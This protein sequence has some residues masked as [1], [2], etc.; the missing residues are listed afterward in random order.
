[1][2]LDGLAEHRDQASVRGT[3]RTGRVSKA[4]QKFLENDCFADQVAIKKD[5]VALSKAAKQRRSQR[6]ARGL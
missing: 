1:M 6:K 4:S 2:D 5:A 3:A